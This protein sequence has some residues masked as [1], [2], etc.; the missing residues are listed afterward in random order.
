MQSDD[1][2]G[3]CYVNIPN[4]MEAWHKREPGDSDK[5]FIVVFDKDTQKYVFCI[6]YVYNYWNRVAF[7][8]QQF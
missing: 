3:N 4:T 8:D 5:D 7:F 6:K 2:T 1:R